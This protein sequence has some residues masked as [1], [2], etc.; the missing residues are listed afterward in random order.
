[1]QKYSP[2][3]RRSCLPHAAAALILAAAL[4]AVNAQ[5]LDYPTPGVP[6]TADGKPNLSAPAPR[7]ADGKPDFSGMW[8]WETP[9]P[10][11]A[12][13]TDS[14]PGWAFMNLATNLKGG[15]PRQ[16]WAEELVKKRG[17]DLAKDDPNVR[18][19]PRGAVRVLTDDY[20]K[21]FFQTPDRVLILTERNMAYRQIFTD[22]RPFPAD[23]N[24]TWNGYSTGKWDGDTLVVQTIG[25]RDDLWLDSA[26]NPLT[27]AA[28]VTEKFQRLNYGTLR[29]DITID[30]PKAY[31][32]PWSIQLNQ[33]I[34][35][36]SE[37][38]DNVCLENEKDSAHMVGK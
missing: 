9:R 20:Y 30:D 22:G 19:L 8:G 25:F 16:P 5:W 28:K 2:R 35:L 36:D 17:A 7:T 24:P 6:R 21:R 15:P 14:S 23:P 3:P 1:M 32:A 34:V 33:P 11:G 31:T 26:G 13:C 12:H 29:V 4:P 27:S 38:I 18:C 37:L 10:C